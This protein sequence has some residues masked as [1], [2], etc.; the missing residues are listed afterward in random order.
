MKF[1]L[2]IMM[3]CTNAAMATNYYVS[4]SGNDSSDGQSIS[5]A[6]KT[7]NKVN[8]GNYN[9]GDIILFK[10]G[11]VFRG[12]L[13]VPM[14]GCTYGAYGS[15]ANPTING[16]VVLSAWTVHTGSIY[17]AT[18]TGNKIP[19]HLY[20]N[21]Q[22]MFTA[23]YPNTGWLETDAGSPNKKTIKSNALGSLGKPA[24][25]WNGANIHVRSFS[26]LFNNRTVTSSS[27]N[28]DVVMNA[29]LDQTNSNTINPG[30]GFYLDNKLSELDAPGEWFFDPN[31]KTVYLYAPGGANPN[32]LLVEAAVEEFGIKIFF[33][34][35]VKIQDLTI[36][37]T[38]DI[39][40]Q[41]WLSDG[42]T[43]D[44]CIIEKVPSGIH[45]SWNCQNLKITNN[46]IRDCYDY[47]I[48]WNEAGDFDNGNDLIQGNQIK[49]IGMVPGYGGDGVVHYIGV[50][51]LGQNM[52]FIKNTIDSTGY[53]C[54]LSE[55][56]NTLIE[57]NVFN[58]SQLLL[59]DGGALY[60]NANNQTIRNNF[61]L[62]SFGNRDFSSGL[63][64]GSNF[65]IMGMGIFSQGGFSG[66]FIEANVF[67]YNRDNGLYLDNHGSVT[68]K[69][70][71]MFN[72][73][74]QIDLTTNYGGKANMTGNTLY[75][76]L[77]SQSLIEME[78]NPLD[79]ANTF[80][81]AVYGNPYG[82]N[83]IKANNNTYTFT[84]WRS[85][86]PAVD[87]SAVNS[88]I[89]LVYIDSLTAISK[90]LLIT[91]PSD[92]PL[93][94][95]LNNKTY[96][97]PDGS[98]ICS[99]QIIVSPWSA[100]LLILDEEGS[101]PIHT[102]AS[103]IN[104]TANAVNQCKWYN[105]RKNNQSLVSINPSGSNLGNVNTNTYL[106]S[107]SQT[108]TGNKA[109][110]RSWVISPTQT[111]TNDVK[112][113]L[114]FTQ[115]E[116]AA[117]KA[118]DPTIITTADL[119]IV[120]YSG[121]NQDS[122][123]SN[124]VGAST[125]ILN[126]SFETYEN[127]YYAEFLVN[128]FS[129]F[130]ITSKLNGTLPLNLLSFNA[131]PQ[132]NTVKLTW[133]TTQEENT[134][135]FDIE[136]SS[137]A[138]NF[139]KIGEVKAINT[140]KNNNYTFSDNKPSVAEIIYY[141]LKMI[142]KDGRFTYSDIRQVKIIAANNADLRVYYALGSNELTIDIIDNKIGTYKY[143]I[144]DAVGNAYITN[145]INHLQ[146]KSTHSVD[147]SSLPPGIYLF[148]LVDNKKQQVQ[149]FIKF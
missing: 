54:M 15:G 35:N 12:A 135:K 34:N 52:N 32:S 110:T 73:K 122:I 77:P 25:Y 141:R 129:E 134:Q 7:I 130:W 147:I 115:A 95:S 111:P 68:I 26:W 56:N 71:L 21:G 46:K 131:E 125:N 63:Y 87:V 103:A 61:F 123:F 102:A 117:L 94:V 119:K 30:W 70:N 114:Y 108:V 137:D 120:K 48:F 45:Q 81:N 93:A 79:Y 138:S 55:A 1:Y 4:T 90:H 98:Y 67:A 82:G 10:R 31:T 106:S 85:A 14:T 38:T 58:H 47:G 33:K 80:N 64:N 53:V 6:W 84:T 11:E 113:R 149:K 76:L 17:K 127:G 146:T 124:N 59:D 96:R 50:R 78:E 88:P 8:Q 145:G 43:I 144:Y 16:A 23:R 37:M 74:I 44:N 121:I 148:V 99:N 51:I 65:R 29:D 39:G 27:S 60:I 126:I 57:K 20:V 72:N 109:L 128:S 104:Q 42:V 118:L 86:F 28:G 24:G 3:F 49:R 40:V 69:D 139:V 19:S 9:D 132:N 100:Q 107:V 143:S 22:L 89:S 112:V 133:Q 62:N 105:I 136:V 75:N 91:N 2:L 142:D 41:P 66:S 13:D 83:F 5:T 18:L 101:V 140:V 36:N 97:K 116:F 92:D